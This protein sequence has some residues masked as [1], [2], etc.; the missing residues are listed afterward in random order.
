MTARFQFQK[1]SGCEPEG[2][3]QQDELLGGKPSVVKYE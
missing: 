2:A 3:W 1:E